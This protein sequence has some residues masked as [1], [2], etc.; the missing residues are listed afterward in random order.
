MSDDERLDHIERKIDDL[1][2]KVDNIDRDLAKYRG[3]V[4]GVLLVV[5]AIVTFVK[6]TWDWL[7]EH[8]KFT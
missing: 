4:G 5:T 1:D 8:I 2:T 7:V 6:L 3:M